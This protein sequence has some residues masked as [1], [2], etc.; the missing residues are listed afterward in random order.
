VGVIG[1]LSLLDRLANVEQACFQQFIASQSGAIPIKSGFVI[2][3]A[4]SPAALT[5][6]TPIPGSPGPNGS[7][8][9][10]CKILTIVDTNGAG[11]TTGTPHTLS[12]AANVIAGNWSQFRFGNLREHQTSLIAVGGAALQLFA[13]NGLWYPLDWQLASV[14]G[15]FS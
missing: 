8:G 6:A 7:G 11:S 9:D 13:Y 1:G 10:D 14:V 12:T 2:I 5:L 15:N 4:P 3:T